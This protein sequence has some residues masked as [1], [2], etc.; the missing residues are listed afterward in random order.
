MLKNGFELLESENAR[1][2]ERVKVLL[3]SLLNWN[4]P[5]GW[6]VAL[7]MYIEVRTQKKFKELDRLFF[8]ICGCSIREYFNLLRFERAKELISYHEKPIHHIAEQLG[9]GS[10]ETLSLEFRRRPKLNLPEFVKSGHK[11]RRPVDAP[12]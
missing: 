11:Y 1:I 6:P 12:V 7:T 10:A 2:I 5:V 8:S 3:I 4:R 9:Y